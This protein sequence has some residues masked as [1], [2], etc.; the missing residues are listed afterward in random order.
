MNKARFKSRLARLRA[1]V[2]G[3]PEIELR[4]S[5]R[6]IVAEIAALEAAAPPA[7]E[8]KAPESRNRKRGSGYDRGK[9]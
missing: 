8:R 2:E 5:L 1:R 9:G 3:Q 4:T 7:P 6:A